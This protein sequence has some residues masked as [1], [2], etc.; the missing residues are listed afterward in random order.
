MARDALSLAATYLRLDPRDVVL[1]PAYLC[2]E[3]WRP[4]HERSQ[5]RF[6]DVDDGLGVAPAVIERLLVSQKARLVVI[7]NYF[8]FLQPF[9]QEIAQ[10]C[11]R[12]EAV[13]LEDC[14]HSLLTAGSGEAGDLSVVS[15]RKMLPVVDGG[16]LALKSQTAGFEPRFHPR[17]FSDALSLLALAKAVSGVQSSKLS[18]AGVA[19][20]RRGDSEGDSSPSDRRV[21]PLSWFAR[22]G[23][24]RAPVTEIVGRRRADY[25]FWSSVVSRLPTVSP[26]L[27][28]IPDGVC[29]LGFPALVQDRPTFQTHLEALGVPT[30][31]HWNLLPHLGAECRNSHRLSQHMLTLPVYPE[32]TNQIKASVDDALR[33]GRLGD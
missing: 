9:R 8:G 23:I 11:A 1:L 28:P 3:V 24:G 6:Y 10:L 22:N 27:G 17:L 29:P 25:A 26:V 14:A 30:K 32:L 4:F 20:H 18:R 31:V 15:Y 2:K 21:L 5:V 19:D 16:A 12:H 33:S 13:M 7:I